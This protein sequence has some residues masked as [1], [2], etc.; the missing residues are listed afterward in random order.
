MNT[1]PRYWRIRATGQAQRRKI[2]AA[3]IH[4][5]LYSWSG[6]LEDT[7]VFALLTLR[8]ESQKVL[9]SFAPHQKSS[10]NRTIIRTGFTKLCYHILATD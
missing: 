6:K 10:S 3:E 8:W 2:G 9:S 7:A 1:N 5:E 4:D